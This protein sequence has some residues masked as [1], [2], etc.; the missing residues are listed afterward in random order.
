MT[1]EQRLQRHVEKI[2]RWIAESGYMLAFTGAEALY[3]DMGHFGKRA[4]RA[5]WFALVAPALV[6]NYF[7]QGAMMLHDPL[8]ARNP[9]YLLAPSWLLPMLIVLAAAATVIASQA[10]ISG[11]FSVARQALNLGFLPRLRAS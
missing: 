1:A 10:V 9:F 6:L 3:A 11:V 2:A 5:A 4:V 8:A 7:G